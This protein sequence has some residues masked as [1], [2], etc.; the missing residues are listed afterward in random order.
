MRTQL[1]N[2]METQE[3]QQL[4]ATT[5]NRM[6][7]RADQDLKIMA[8]HSVFAN[9]LKETNHNHNLFS[10]DNSTHFDSHADQ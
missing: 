1:A 6:G 10:T 7:I 9:K 8:G 3:E 5:L 4:R 2:S